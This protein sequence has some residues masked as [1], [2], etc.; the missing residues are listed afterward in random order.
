M[1]ES[2]GEGTD[3]MNNELCGEGRR[4]LGDKSGVEVD[5]GWPRGM[6]WTTET[7]PETVQRLIEWF[8]NEMN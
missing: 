4:L 1:K 6:V 3:G 8:S 5:E 7:T 2:H